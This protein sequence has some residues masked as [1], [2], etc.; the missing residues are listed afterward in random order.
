M[1]N[2]PV[3]KPLKQE[4][5]LASNFKLSVFKIGNI[6]LFCQFEPVTNHKDFID[7]RFLVVD[8]VSVSILFVAP[9]F[10]FFE[11]SD[12]RN[13]AALDNSRPRSGRSARPYSH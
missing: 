6:A 11:Y 10:F 1:R 2:P 5:G 4:L 12:I 13:F 3:L 8:V 7:Y 9:V